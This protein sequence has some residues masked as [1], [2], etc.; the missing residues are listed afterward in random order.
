MWTL[1]AEMLEDV[2]LIYMENGIQYFKS[3]SLENSGR[4]VDV[5]TTYR[6]KFTSLFLA[7][8]IRQHPFAFPLA[9]PRSTLTGRPSSFLHISKSCLRFNTQPWFLLFSEV[10]R[11]GQWSVGSLG[12]SSCLECSLGITPQPPGDS[13]V[14]P[15]LR[16]IMVDTFSSP[17]I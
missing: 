17:N 15:R 4:M 10:F 16:T 9:P 3:A 11:L 6:I 1:D 13:K 5:P 7:W 8:L 12:F 14:L 2:L